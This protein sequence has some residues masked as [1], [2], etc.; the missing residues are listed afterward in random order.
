MKDFEPLSEELRTA[1]E[2]AARNIAKDSDAM[3]LELERVSDALLPTIKQAGIRF[4]GSETWN[5]TEYDRRTCRIGIR[6]DNGRW[7]FGV[8][9]S[10]G[11]PLKEDGTGWKDAF[12]EEAYSTVYEIATMR[13]FSV[14]NH[15][16]MAQA[17]EHLPNFFEEYLNELE[18]TEKEYEDLRAMATAIREIVEG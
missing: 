9:R 5:S 3:R 17:V 4:G 1:A 18:S 8:E 16:D 2:A 11:A 13:S 15:A 6:N 10:S 7:T 14:I 12:S